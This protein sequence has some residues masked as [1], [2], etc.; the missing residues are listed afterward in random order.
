MTDVRQQ[1]EAPEELAAVSRSLGHS[2]LS[3]TTDVYAHLT[4]GMQQRAAGRMDAIIRRTEGRQRLA[5]VRLQIETP[6]EGLRG[7]YSC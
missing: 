6:S 2:N 7:D 4:R 5:G 3:M 1:S